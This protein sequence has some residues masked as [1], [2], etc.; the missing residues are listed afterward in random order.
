MPTKPETLVNEQAKIVVDAVTRAIE[1]L[2][3]SPWSTFPEADE[4]V[5]L[6]RSVGVMASS[7]VE[8]EPL[9]IS[10]ATLRKLSA[11]IADLR[12]TLVNLDEAGRGPFNQKTRSTLDEVVRAGN[13]FCDAAL[14]VV[15]FL[16]TKDR[17]QLDA[18]SV[19]LEQCRDDA[20]RTVNLAAERLAKIEEIE[21]RAAGA[22]AAIQQSSGM[23]GVSRYATT[24]GT[25]ATDHAKY[26]D[27][28]LAATITIGVLSVASVWL[29]VKGYPLD[30]GAKPA[31]IV[32]FVMTRAV[33][34]A[35]ASYLTV[36]ASRNYRAH[37]HLQ[38][39]N[40]H[41]SLALQTFETFA[42]AAK[43]DPIRDA[44]LLEAT[45]CIFAHGSSGYTGEEPAGPTE[46]VVE[47]MRTIT[48]KH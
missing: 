4:R 10:L 5:Q 17:R 48:G 21:G 34:F 45:K 37:R 24:F 31:S 36:W 3:S 15:A 12:Q 6:L 44:V 26:A 19:E 40:E 43:E 38:V 30:D 20:G 33:A 13:D 28:W 2:R 1:L 39:T 32:Q 14:P 18:L 27:R 41:R 16:A 25:V 8:A 42:A 35:L 9:G 7:L 22:F 23:V 47:I 11:T 29:L 46:R